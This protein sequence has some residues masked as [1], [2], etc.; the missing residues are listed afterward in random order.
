MFAAVQVFNFFVFIIGYFFSDISIIDISWGLMPLV[1]LTM[2]LV[3][4]I[5]VVGAESLT[6]MSLIVYGL[7]FIWG[8]RL[9]WHIGVRHNGLD[10]RY[11]E[12][13]KLDARCPQ[14]CHGFMT[15]FRNFFF[16]GAAS[17][18]MITPAIYIWVYSDPKDTVGV[19]EIIGITV[20]VT[21]ILFEVIGDHQLTKF[22]ANPNKVPGSC[23]DTGVW[24]ITRH[25]NYFGDCM[26]WYGIYFMACG[27]STGPA[28]GYWTFY[29]PLLMTFFLRIL[30]GTLI[31]EAGQKRKPA[32]RIYML[33]TNCFVPWFYKKIEGQEREELMAKYKIEC[34]EYKK[35]IKGSILWGLYK[36]EWKKFLYKGG[37]PDS[38]DDEPAAASKNN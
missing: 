33:E 38:D 17:S 1:P 18:C 36:R 29:S 24:R 3:E 10:A 21:G 22:I 26:L 16:Q 15:W 11:K 20:W 9:A 12:L 31:N 35:N 6:V 13:L 14:P 34:E 8:T 19:L 23:I 7:V 25:P 5:A 37:P 32:Y 4:R 2:L 27:G 28:G 30:T